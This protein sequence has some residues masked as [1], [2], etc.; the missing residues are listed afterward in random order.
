MVFLQVLAIAATLQ[1]G[2]PDFH[3]SGTLAAGKT[4]EIKGVNGDISASPASGNQVEVV[5]AKRWRKS[6]PASVEIKVVQDG[7]GVTICALYPSR[8]HANSCAAGE[9]GQNSDNND[10]SVAF[11]V[12]VPAGVKFEGRTVNGGVTAT[13]LRADASV[14]TVNGSVSVQTAGFAEGET[15]NG[16]VDV[17][18]GRIDSDKSLSFSTVNGSVDVTI[19]ANAALDVRANTTNGDITTDFPL[20]VSGRFGPRQLKGTIGGGGRSMS[21][22]TVNG[23]IKIHKGS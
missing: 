2:S 14:S 10:V 17:V 21:L 7:D 20:T 16:D 12:K 11:T 13:D 4:I 18:M 5:A 22:T 9:G 8:R 19:P 15:V 6:D 3:W 23:N 1:Q